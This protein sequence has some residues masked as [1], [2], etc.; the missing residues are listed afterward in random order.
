MLVRACIA[1]ASVLLI[2]LVVV[3]P[4]VQNQVTFA[5]ENQEESSTKNT[6]DQQ[7]INEEDE[8]S[9]TDVLN[10]KPYPKDYANKM[11]CVI[12]DD[13]RQYDVLS[14]RF[15]VLEVRRI[16]EEVVIQFDA[17]CV[18]LKPNSRLGFQMRT[19]NG[20]LCKDDHISVFSQDIFNATAGTSGSCRIPGFEKVSEVQLDQLK[21]GIALKVVE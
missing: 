11:N 13:V 21:R 5:D 17:I 20:R 3:L 14:S 10:R 2:G 8:L 18:G 15:I 19:S 4:F 9:L 12:A 1:L 7:K 6:E 16:D